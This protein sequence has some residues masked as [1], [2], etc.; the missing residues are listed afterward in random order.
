MILAFGLLRPYKGIDVLL[1]AFRGSRAPS[2]GSSASRGCRSS[3]ARAGAGGRRARSAS[4]PASSP[5]AEIPAFFR[6]ADVVVLPYRDVEQSGVLY[7]ALAFGKPMVLSAVGGFPEIA[8]QGA[9]RLVPPGDPGRSPRPSRE[10]LADRAARGTLCAA[11]AREAAAT[12][13]S[14][15]RIGQATLALY[16]ELLD[17]RAMSRRRPII[18]R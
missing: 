4:S 7:T 13:Y 8:E 11:A 10:L 1:E 3:A 15:D 16:R 5:D 9:A 18:P 14:W 6:R 2:S 12:T 17:G